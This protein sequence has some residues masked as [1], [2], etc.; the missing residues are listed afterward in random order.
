LERNLRA[1][2]AEE[3]IREMKRKGNPGR[4]GGGAVGCPKKVQGP[5]MIVDDDIGQQGPIYYSSMDNDQTIVSSDSV[6]GRR[7]S[8]AQWLQ[9]SRLP[10]RGRRGGCSDAGEAQW[11]ARRV[12]LG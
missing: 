11:S 1:N 9:S 7:R 4:S 3:E 5:H 12:A 10:R 6:V 2:V 8:R